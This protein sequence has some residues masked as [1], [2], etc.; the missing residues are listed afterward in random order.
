MIEV[1]NAIT[2]DVN[3]FKEILN[4]IELFPADMLDDMI[5]NYFNNPESMDVWFTALEE[6]VVVGL[7]YCVPEQ[8]TDGTFNLLAIGV[9]SDI[10]GKGIGRKMM[11]FIE[12]ELKE[13]GHRLLIV[14]TSGTDAFKQTRSF[15]EKLGYTKE[16]VIRDFW[17]EG[18]DKVVYWKKLS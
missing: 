5:H 11:D 8:L 18:D 14:D 1:R 9:R 15:Y 4:T 17:E 10:Q 6:D 7:G 12:G 2:S 16:A 3:S 13:R